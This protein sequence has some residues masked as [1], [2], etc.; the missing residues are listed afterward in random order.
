MWATVPTPKRWSPPPT[1]DPRAM[2]TTPNSPSPARQS[3]ISFR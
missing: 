3:S 2:S 1:S